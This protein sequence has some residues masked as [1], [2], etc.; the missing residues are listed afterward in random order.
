MGSHA[1]P[2]HRHGAATWCKCSLH[3]L[4][5][6][7][8]ARV[9]VLSLLTQLMGHQW[10]RGES[11]ADIALCSY[12]MNL[13]LQGN[14]MWILLCFRVQTGGTK[15]VL[16][17]LVDCVMGRFIWLLRLKVAQWCWLLYKLHIVQD[18]VVILWLQG[19]FNCILI[20]FKRYLLHFLKNSKV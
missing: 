20:A 14:F 6:L 8:V 11:G 7:Q 3:I 5:L 4:L 12:F 15:I 9:V 10:P 16:W 19:G 17:H 18:W 2:G 1:F 13:I